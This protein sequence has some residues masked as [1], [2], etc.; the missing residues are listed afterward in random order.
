MSLLTLWE[1][2]DAGA[3]RAVVCGADTAVLD[4]ATTSVVSL[5]M[6]MIMVTDLVVDFADQTLASGVMQI[7]LLDDR[8]RV[9]DFT[10]LNE[11]V[12]DQV[13]D[14]LILHFGLRASWCIGRKL[15]SKFADRNV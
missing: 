13:I 12:I 11:P 9:I 3:A 1:N 6:V 4:T 8:Q 14:K 5:L 15:L 2:A 10:L 7:F